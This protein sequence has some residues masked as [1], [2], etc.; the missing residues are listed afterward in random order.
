M[1]EPSA[2]C[3]IVGGGIGGAVLALAL[4]RRGH[5]VVVLER[6]L[7]PPFAARPEVLARS[8]IEAFRRLGLSAALLREAALPLRR[9]ELWRSGGGR[10]LELTE[11]DFRRVGAQPYS[12]DPAKTRHILLE[13]A[14]STQN[15]ELHRGVEVRTLAREG[16][17]HITVHGQR[18]QEPVAWRGRLVV[19]DDGTR[20]RIRV[21]L[22][23]PL[24]LSEF[25]LDFLAAAGPALPDA[26]EDVGQAWADPSAL[27]NGIVL[28]VFMPLP[29]A[30]TAMALLASPSA[31]ERLLR[32]PPSAFYEAAARLSPRCR[33][34]A[35]RYRCPEDFTHIRRPFGHAARYID[36]AAALMGDAAHPV[37]PAG[38]QGANM[39]VADALALA[40]VVQQALSLNDCSRSR[41]EPY[42]TIRRPA[43]ERSL[44]FSVRTD[45]VFRTLQRH[46][47]MATLFPMS[48]ALVN[49]SRTLK[50]R[51]I[52]AVSQAFASA[53]PAA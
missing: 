15:V 44:Q 5:R 50:A 46:P 52:R 36:D 40:D 29:G 37:T 25:A 18:D 53:P 28:G 41:L 16:P 49:R 14:V 10:M 22:G 27:Q 48:L 33:A 20:S 3:V 24:E 51:L 47:W 23:I 12:T 6:E 7:H 31:C 26:A 42:E 39:S 30:R 19:G 17:H 1:G 2:D 45:R 8:T 35:E 38:G 4:G 13:A 21:A 11:D 9:L 43:N 34:L 32:A